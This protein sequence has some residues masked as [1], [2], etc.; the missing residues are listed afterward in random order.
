MAGKEKIVTQMYQEM[1]P[2]A[3]GAVTPRFRKVSA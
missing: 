2:L 3:D 1:G